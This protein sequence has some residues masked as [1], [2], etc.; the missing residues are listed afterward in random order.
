MKSYVQY[1]SF[2][3]D[4]Y[5]FS[6]NETV[7]FR[8]RRIVDGNTTDMVNT[9]KVQELPP[10][11]GAISKK[12]TFP[13][14]H[15]FMNSP[16]SLEQY[17]AV[18]DDGLKAGLNSYIMVPVYP[19]NQSNPAGEAMRN[20]YRNAVNRKGME[21]YAWVLF[22]SPLVGAGKATNLAALI[23]KYPDLEAVY[24]NNTGCQNPRWMRQYCFSKALGKY[25]KEFREALKKDYEYMITKGNVKSK[26]FFLNDES[27]PYGF[28]KDWKHCFCF[29]KDCKAGFGA[30]SG[31]PGAEK[32]DDVT[33]VTKY[34]AQ[35][36][37][38][39]KFKQKNQ[40]LGMTH[41]IIKELGGTLWYYHNTHDHEAYKHSRGKY[42]LVSIPVPGQIY[43]GSP[44]QGTMDAAKQIGEK[45]TGVHN[46]FGQIHTYFPGEAANP[47]VFYSSDS[48]FY[49]PKEQKLVLV[50]MAATTHKGA[51]IESAAYCSAGTF[52]YMGEAMRLIAAFEDLFYDGVRDDKLASS[53]VFKYPNML[54]LKKGDERLVLIFNEDHVKPLR[55]ILKNLTLKPGQKAVVWESGKPYG[56][57]DSMQ[58]TVKP[59]DVV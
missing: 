9:I 57:A 19:M 38:W 42:D 50:R 6:K 13:Q 29:C 32:L 3:H 24:Y 21:N 8:F 10:I 40:I 53:S 18:V 12:I 4:G 26:K 14:Y 39:W 47:T 16:V 17:Q 58:I 36:N 1:I 44:V 2:R 33:I 59:Q 5:K 31:I 35:W 49:H 45:I 48:N 37:K 51:I 54:V 28:H 15:P 30:M 41:E 25:R 22:N 55:G 20:A 27:Y 7:D 11:N 46:S 23:D 56:K 34:P 52:Y 43:P